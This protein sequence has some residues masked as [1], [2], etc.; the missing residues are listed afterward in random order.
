MKIAPIMVEL[1]ADS[2]PFPV[3]RKIQK[4]DIK[5]GTETA[6]ANI[7]KINITLKYDSMVSVVLI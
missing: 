2:I 5:I 3:R 4:K 7:K 6:T 1:I